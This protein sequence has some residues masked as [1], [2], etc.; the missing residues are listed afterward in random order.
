MYEDIRKKAVLMLEDNEFVSTP[1]MITQMLRL[2]QILSGHL[3]SDDVYMISFPSRRLD[4][5]LEIFYV[6]PNKVI[7]LS[8]FRYDIVSIVKALNS[9]NKRNVAKS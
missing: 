5:L 1:S 6:S 8:R 3:K 2:Q 7:I 9:K 4:E